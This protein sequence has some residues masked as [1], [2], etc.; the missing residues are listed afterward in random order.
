MKKLPST[1][2][3][4]Q[5]ASFR[6]VSWQP[7]ELTSLDKFN[8]LSENDKYLFE[9]T[10]HMTYYSLGRVRTTTS[11]KLVAGVVSMAPAKTQSGSVNV[12]YAGEFN[13]NTSPIVT[14]GLVVTNAND[15][16]SLLTIRGLGTSLPSDSGF[17]FRWETR[18]G[19]AAQRKRFGTVYCNYMALGVYTRVTAAPE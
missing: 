10:A 19:S 1:R 5:L 6:V 9:N 17:Q 18:K 11:L 16:F 8:Q 4:N 12:S 3:V 13:S 15:H 14:T 7:H 2:K